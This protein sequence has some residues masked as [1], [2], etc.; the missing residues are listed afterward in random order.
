MEFCRFKLKELYDGILQD[1]VG[2]LWVD[3]EESRRNALNFAGFSFNFHQ[4]PDGIHIGSLAVRVLRM[5][6]SRHSGTCT[7]RQNGRNASKSAKQ[8]TGDLIEFR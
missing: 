4:N 7:F 1:F 5:I 3:K 8:P 6:R 2:V